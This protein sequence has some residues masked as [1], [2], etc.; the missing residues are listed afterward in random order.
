M[1]FLKKT[2]IKNKIKFGHDFEWVVEWAAFDVLALRGLRVLHYWSVVDMVS[3][4]RTG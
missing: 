4:N 3:T 1:I 2:K